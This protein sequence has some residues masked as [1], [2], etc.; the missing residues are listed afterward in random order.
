MKQLVMTL[1]KPSALDVVR[2]V[3]LLHG[4]MPTQKYQGESMA[5][6]KENLANEPDEAVIVTADSRLLKFVNE[7]FQL[8]DVHIFNGEMLI[9]LEQATKRVLRPAHNL[10]NLYEAGE[11]H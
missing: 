10:M 1:E 3:R 7:E 9:P 6:I 4:T 11:F 8:R 5:K 2:A